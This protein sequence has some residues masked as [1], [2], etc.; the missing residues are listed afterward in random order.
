MSAIAKQIHS[1]SPSAAQAAGKVIRPGTT[2]WTIEDFADRAID[3]PVDGDEFELVDG[4]LRV[5]APFGIRSGE[6]ANGLRDL[7]VRQIHNGRFYQEVDLLLR[8]PDRTARPDLFY[9][10]SAQRVRQ[11]E[12]EAERGIGKND[13][14][15]VFV[16]PALVVESISIGHERHDRVTKRRYYAE[17]RVAHYWLLDP[18]DESLECLVLDGDDY[19]TEAHGRRSDVVKSAALGGIEIPLDQIWPE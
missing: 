9:M 15:P 6:P 4:V 16:P 3:W 2:G 14:R 12:I 7:L 1:V 13:Y 17:A 11:K 18:A 19:R 10:T 5:M 8:D